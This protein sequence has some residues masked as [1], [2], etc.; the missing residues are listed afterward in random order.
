MRFAYW[1]QDVGFVE[2]SKPTVQSPPVVQCAL[3]HT[4]HAVEGQF[5]P[6]DDKVLIIAIIFWCHLSRRKTGP[7]TPTRPPTP[8][9]SRTRHLLPPPSRS[10]S[11]QGKEA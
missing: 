8:S 2:G 5:D 11:H 9:R 4:L 6:G 3:V 7:S 10:G 1:L